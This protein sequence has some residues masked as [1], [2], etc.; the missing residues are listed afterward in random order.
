MKYFNSIK[1]QLKLKKLLLFNSPR[2]IFQFH[3]GTIKAEV[4]MKNSPY[5]LNFNSIK[6]QLKR[7]LRAARRGRGLFQFHKGTIKANMVISSVKGQQDFNSIKV[8]LKLQAV[9]KT[10]LA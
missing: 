6:V 7:A 8:Q 2:F 9:M 3:K 5:F 4:T 1:V 10:F